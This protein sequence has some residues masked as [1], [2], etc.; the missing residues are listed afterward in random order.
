M[1]RRPPRSTLF[2]Y[3]TLFRSD[4]EEG[5]DAL[6]PRIVLGYLDARAGEPRAVHAGDLLPARGPRVEPPELDAQD[7]ALEPLHAIVVADVLV[8][9]APRLAVVA[10]RAREPRDA[11]AVGGERAA[12]AA[13]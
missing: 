10:E 2:P 4:D 13:G 9:V 6:G 1:I 12:L 5:V 7:G 3:T 11:V 8:E